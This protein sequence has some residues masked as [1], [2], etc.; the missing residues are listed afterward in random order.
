MDA[1]VGTGL[2]LFYWLRFAGLAGLLGFALW[3]ARRRWLAAAPE[4][5]ARRNL[6]PCLAI[7]LG[8]S[9]YLGLLTVFLA[10]FLILLVVAIAA[11]WVMVP[12]LAS[13]MILDL[14]AKLLGAER[15]GF[16]FGAGILAFVA[17]DFLWLGLTGV[18]HWPGGPGLWPEYLAL[19]SI[20]AAAA[21]I[22]WSYLPGGGGGDIA[23]AFD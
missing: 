9:I 23:T 6:F 2:A 11:F 15:D 20:P 4:S 19:T 10:P 12:A 17:A 16:W 3:L 18:G 1:G 21:I 22:W 5:R 14:A 13:I 8:F 7:L